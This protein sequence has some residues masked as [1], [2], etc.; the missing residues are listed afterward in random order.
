MVYKEDL[1]EMKKDCLWRIGEG[2]S[3]TVEYQ[4][5]NSNSSTMRSL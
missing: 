3:L 1:F 4:K 5:D 2:I